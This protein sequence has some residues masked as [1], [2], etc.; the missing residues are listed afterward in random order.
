MTAADADPPGS[1]H[2]GNDVIH[3]V[4][5]E[6][7]ALKLDMWMEP[8]TRIPALHAHPEQREH[9]RVISG[10]FHVQVDRTIR[11]LQAGESITIEPGVRHGVGNTGEAAAV[12]YTEITPG[13]R[14]QE[15]FER[16][17][18]LEEQRL[19]TISMTLKYGHLVSQFRREYEYSPP[20]TLLFR[21]FSLTGRIFARPE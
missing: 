16:L 9:F 13:L 11:Q 19:D 15:F 3:Q 10:A 6:L 1:Y 7:A 21:I 8:G 18:L 12:V 4:G 5:D 2:S 14:T 20:V 17:R